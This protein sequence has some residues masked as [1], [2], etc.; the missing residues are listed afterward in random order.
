M[1]LF[2]FEF[3][4]ISFSLVPVL[5]SLDYFGG[6]PFES[7]ETMFGFGF[8][9]IVL[10][11]ATGKIFDANR[12][13]VLTFFLFLGILASL[14]LGVKRKK[15]REGYILLNFFL[16]LLLMMGQTS[17]S[18]LKY[19]PGIEVIQFSRF[20]SGVHLFGIMLAGIG[21]WFFYER[22]LSFFCSLFSKRKNIAKRVL[23]VV[24]GTLAA[25]LLLSQYAVFQEKT[26]TFAFEKE[27]PAYLDV[28]H[29][30]AEQPEGRVHVN[31]NTGITTHF[32]LYTPPLVAKKPMVIS[33]SA[34]IHD[35][36]GFFYV[37]TMK[38]VT[39]AFLELF[40]IKYII[41]T[42]DMDFSSVGK[43]L[44]SN[45]YYTL[46]KTNAIGYF[47]VIQTQ[48]VILSKNK[49]AREIVIEWAKSEE[50]EKKNFLTIADGREKEYFVN[51]GYKNFISLDAITE[52]FNIS[53]FMKQ[54]PIAENCG[55]VIEEHIE[56]GYYKAQVKGNMQDTACYIL[57][58]VNAHKDWKALLDGK[59]VDWIQVSPSFMAVQLPQG[60]HVIEFEF[61]IN[62]VRKILFFISLITLLLL[63]YFER[64]S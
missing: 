18:F 32:R 15:Q 21:F 25:Y 23:A 33:Y 1:K 17:F 13:P 31:G 49:E 60:E 22:S 43:R 29:V 58:K 37:E 7:R 47:D 39:P 3:L 56:D 38:E 44:Y 51:N 5:T 42:K 57:L 8:Q 4:I 30:L 64:R 20:W 12:L 28:L 52:S 26:K 10:E 53:S 2:F 55:E 35:S 59:E 36:L 6:Q 11:L 54:K 41:A 63:W 27:D 14:F 48:T 16:F 40:N 34:G 61:G 24:A 62:N 50:L 45:E 46:Y 9:T 19:F